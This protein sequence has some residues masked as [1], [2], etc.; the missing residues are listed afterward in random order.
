M[1]NT[2]ITKQVIQSAFRDL[3]NEKKFG[4]I[5]VK[6][7]TDRCG[8][9][10]NT[11]YYHYQDVPALLEEI[12]ASDVDRFIQEHLTVNSMEECLKI[13]MDYVIEHKKEILHV[14][15]SNNQSIY[16]TYVWRMCEYTVS[17]YAKTMFSD[18]GLKEEDMALFI[19]FYKCELFGL[20]T[21][22][23]ND[24]MK[25]DYMQG[26]L[27]FALLRKGLIEEHINK[28]KESEEEGKGSDLS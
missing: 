13:A 7:I 5:T 20:M 21:D 14:C 8:I 12:F 16:T 11:F 18:V 4:K 3:L 9:N 2:N 1:A 19:R 10:R 17:S 6:D 28:L 25:E 27:R 24:G 23:I 22:W 15:N 26:V